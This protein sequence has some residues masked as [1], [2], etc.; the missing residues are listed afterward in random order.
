MSYI[1]LIRALDKPYS[2]C[3]LFTICSSCL[4]YIY[5][6]YSILILIFA[7]PALFHAPH[8]L[9]HIMLKP[10]LPYPITTCRISL[11]HIICSTICQ[12]LSTSPFILFYTYC[13]A[14]PFEEDEQN[15]SIWFLDHNFHEN[16]WAMFKKV[17]GN[18]LPS[19]PLFPPFISL[20]YSPMSFCFPIFFPFIHLLYL[21]LS[22]SP[23][24][25]MQRV[26]T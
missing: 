1:S 7:I 4:S 3:T 20:L 15:P 26:R 12:S 16:M 22:F 24:E 25:R 21:C 14:V 11:H 9:P 6:H 18:Y 13:S 17:N 5:I 19:R 10:Y 23:N 8:H 2:N